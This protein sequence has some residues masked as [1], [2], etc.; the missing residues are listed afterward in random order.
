MEFPGCYILG[1]VCLGP[2]WSPKAY[3]SLYI[4]LCIQ[5]RVLV[6]LVHAEFAAFA[7]GFM[8]RPLYVG[9]V[10]PPKPL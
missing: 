10:Q 3:T 1:V 4:S 2:H 9:G 7:Q 6:Q 8:T 5:M